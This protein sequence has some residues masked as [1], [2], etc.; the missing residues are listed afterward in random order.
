MENPDDRSEYPPRN[1]ELDPGE[2]AAQN[3]RCHQLLTGSASIMKRAVVAFLTFMCVGSAVQ[4]ESFPSRPIRLV[5]P[6]APGGSA[7]LLG[8]LVGQQLSELY[9]QPVVVENKP[10]ASG[11]IGAEYVSKSAPD[12]YTLLL[13]IPPV[14]ASYSIYPKLNYEPARALESLTVIGSFPS[15]VLV[16]NSVPAKDMR[17]LVSLAKATPGALNYGSAGPGAGTHLG[18]ELF[19]QETGVKMTHVPY[20]GSS[21]AASDLMGG[22]IQVMFENLPAAMGLIK[23]GR[24]RALGVTSSS[25]SPSLPNVPTVSEQG[26]PNYEFVGWYTLA[27]PAGLPRDIAQKLSADV[28]RIVNS[29]ALAAK[30]LELGVTPVGGSPAEAAEFVRTEAAKYTRLI[31][32]AKL[33]L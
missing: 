16:N 17:E 21:A 30:W 2:A 22:Q 32:E 33:G 27:A 18:V 13:G 29:P 31:K 6:V 28:A 23:G 5:V 11:H 25:R 12:G 24:V 15:V 19:M 3:P 14:Q 20:K 1:S 10:G 7:D 8:R 26:I 9:K 4:A